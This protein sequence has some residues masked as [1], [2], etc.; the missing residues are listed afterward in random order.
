VKV[1]GNAKTDY[2]FESIGDLNTV[3]YSYEFYK[4]TVVE[5][6]DDTVVEGQDKDIYLNI[7]YN[8]TDTS[9][10][11][12]S[13]QL[14]YNNSYDTITYQ[15]TTDGDLTTR[16]YYTTDNADLININTNYTFYWIYNLSANG[17]EIYNQTDLHN[18]T[19]LNM[20]FSM[21]CTSHPY[22]VYNISLYD[23]ITDEP[24]YGDIIGQPIY[25][26]HGS[27][28]EYENY[29]FPINQSSVQI[30][31]NVNESWT[32]SVYGTVSATAS[33]YGSRSAIIPE[34]GALTATNTAE[35]T[36]DIYL[37]SSANTSLWT[38][39][40]LT[41]DLNPVS[42]GTLYMYK[43]QAGT[44]TLLFTKTIS[45]GAAVMNVVYYSNELYGYSYSIE[46]L[47]DGVL[48]QEG[49]P[50]F[51][52]PFEVIQDQ[53]YILATGAALHPLIELY[54]VSCEFTKTNGDEIKL[55]WAATAETN[56]TGCVDVYR[57]GIYASDLIYTYCEN[58]PTGLIERTITGMNTTNYNYYAYARIIQDGEEAYCDETLYFSQAS[59]TVSRFGL[60]AL[61]AT[62]LFILGVILMN[63]K[64][65]Y[66]VVIGAVLGLLGVAILGIISLPWTVIALM[67][68]MAGFVIWVVRYARQ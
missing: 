65:E 3:T 5:A 12:N 56:I 42:G 48:Y 9:L 39:E 16:Q 11:F 64:T 8:N 34:L 66:H 14:N 52:P 25:F 40:W 49:T 6:Y 50:D 62:I 61:Y 51:Y 21:N 27:F 41:E 35:A 7:T 68:T 44:R 15:E 57:E 30:C 33:G 53:R 10:T 4:V 19:V 1:Y 43:Y 54:D 22:P 45:G 58:T 55:Q 60:E 31:T 20:S 23:E 2:L 17:G 18:Q 37:A 28:Y 46:V 67:V 32:L 29:N 24:V 36:I 59:E 13:I 47:Y 63:S 38:T 26:K